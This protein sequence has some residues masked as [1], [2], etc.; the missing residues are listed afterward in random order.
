M[1]A[2][3]SCGSAGKVTYQHM[4]CP[5]HMDDQSFVVTWHLRQT[6]SNPK[7]NNEY[8][9]KEVQPTW[10]SRKIR[11]DQEQSVTMRPLKT[12]SKK[13]Q[14]SYER[15]YWFLIGT[16]RHIKSQ[17]S[18]QA[19]TLKMIWIFRHSNGIFFRGNVC[20]PHAHQSDNRVRIQGRGQRHDK[21][22]LPTNETTLQNKV[23]IYITCCRRGNHNSW[24]HI[25]ARGN[26]P[27]ETNGT[28]ERSYASLKRYLM[29]ETGRWRLWWL[30]FVRNA[31]VNLNRTNNTPKWL[32][33]S[34]I[35]FFTRNHKS[36]SYTCKG[37]FARNFKHD[38]KLTSKLKFNSILTRLEEFQQKML[39]THLKYP[40][41]KESSA[42]IPKLSKYFYFLNSDQ[43]M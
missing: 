33:P 19:I 38:L 15:L 24:S 16:R 21:T 11:E 18:T 29:L 41:L 14:N 10:P 40:P 26:L 20:V 6:F 30:N 4:F 13:T 3:K 27:W 23:A 42:W 12:P 17:H 39:Q 28:L 31:L 7:M 36:L 35:F 9:W 2:Q 5:L 1:L 34:C 25:V 8:R 37:Y 32:E 22:L 43:S